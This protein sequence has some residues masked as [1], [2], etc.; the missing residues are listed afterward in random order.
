MVG[1]TSRTSQSSRR[2]VMRRFLD[3]DVL[4]RPFRI[5]SVLENRGRAIIREGP[6]PAALREQPQ[7][8][9]HGERASSGATPS[10]RSV[11]RLSRQ[12]GSCE[13]RST[14]ADRRVSGSSPGWRTRTDARDQ[15]DDQVH[16]K[17]LGLAGHH[18]R[19]DR[20]AASSHRGR[21]PRTTHGR[22]GT[23]SKAATRTLC[24]ELV[25]R[26]CLASLRASSTRRC[27]R[28]P[29]QTPRFGPDSAPDGHRNG[30]SRAAH[31]HF[32]ARLP[33]NGT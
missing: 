17:R 6:G 26:P 20:L 28:F 3:T 11:L 14:A 19:R 15:V 30:D 16:N 2:N 22:P 29:V 9:K 1:S 10:R 23:R 27:F 12:P 25:R 32:P 33:V 24:A 5:P 7:T 21:T 8:R 18:P 31:R 4:P 13:F